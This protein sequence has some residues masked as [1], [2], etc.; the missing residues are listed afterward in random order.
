MQCA[1]RRE[2]E[3]P[4]AGRVSKIPI[5][6]SS[7]TFSPSSSSYFVLFPSPLSS[8]FHPLVDFFLF[9][10][11]PSDGP[12]SRSLNHEDTPRDR[13]CSN[14]S[15]RKYLGH[16]LSPPATTDRDQV[17][18]SGAWFICTEHPPPR[19]TPLLPLLSAAI[20]PSIYPSKH[21]SFCPPLLL[22]SLLPCHSLVSSIHP[23]PSRV[24]FIPFMQLSRAA[25]LRGM[26]DEAIVLRLERTN[27]TETNEWTV[28]TTGRSRWTW[29]Q[30]RRWGWRSGGQRA[31]VTSGPLL[32]NGK[33]ESSHLYAAADRSSDK[34]RPC[35]LNFRSL[36][37]SALVHS[38]SSL[39][40]FK[41]YGLRREIFSVIC[42]SIVRS[43]L[44]STKA[45]SNSDIGMKQGKE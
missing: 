14:F 10:S 18:S 35:G 5:F 13:K 30:M 6:L 28:R 23:I 38:R 26:H 3:R 33:M 34:S 11:F 45:I 7:A 20:H 16:R 9:P 39:A 36:T 27:E 43:V 42:L 15:A 8:W 22:L 29:I 25:F 24:S 4:V 37:F 41:W 12:G 40:D 19:L 2:L 31:A 17:N 1:N 44:S 32:V 21:L